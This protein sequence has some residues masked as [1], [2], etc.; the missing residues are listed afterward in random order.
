MPRFT[1]P[2]ADAVRARLLDAARDEFASQGVTGAKVERIAAAADSNKAQL[3]HYFGGKDGLYEALLEQTATELAAEAPLDVDDLAEY[4]GRLH[5]AYTR[6]PWVPRL[7]T[8][9]RL[10]GRP[11]ESLAGAR[12]DAVATV[13][14]AQRAGALPRT[15]RPAV[16]LGLVEHLAVFWAETAPEA[17]GSVAAV[18]PQRRRQAVVEAVAALLGRSGDSRPRGS[19]LGA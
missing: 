17:E 13:E 3:F 6:R 1:P 11:V 19:S 15:F 10:E 14:A 9:H 4:A 16:L 18:A 2:P 12:A 7:L 5:D 8:W